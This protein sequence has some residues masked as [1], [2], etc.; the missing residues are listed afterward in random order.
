M[1][2]GLLALLFLFSSSTYASAL[3]VNHDF[4]VR[5]GVFDAS[6]TSFKY[7]LNKNNYSVN[8]IV[9]T[10]GLFDSLYPFQA[11]YS[12]N[13]TITTQGLKTQSYKYQSK[14]RFN[15]RRKELIYN[16]KGEPI[17]RI[18]TKND[19]EKK[20]KI[21]QQ[22]PNSGTTDLQTVIAELALQ[23]NQVNFCS[24]RMEVFDGKRRYD[25][26]FKDEG[27]EQLTSHTLSPYSGLANKCSMYIDQLGEKGDDLLWELSQDRPIYFW[28]MKDKETNAPFIARILIKDTPLGKLEVFTNKINIKDN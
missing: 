20:V 9:S 12:S 17:Y 25:V 22:A 11:Q 26:I 4:I 5:L 7:T 8:S 3:S 2:K 27:Q 13:G 23:Y 16:D 15:T 10:H 18:S 24:A 28:I 14:S 6:R 21:E 1:K 19:K